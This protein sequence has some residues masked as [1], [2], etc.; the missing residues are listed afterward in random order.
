[1]SI[2]KKL[3]AV[4]SAAAVVAS[5]FAAAPANAETT[6]SF[7]NRTV[8]NNVQRD[9]DPTNHTVKFYSGEYFSLYYGA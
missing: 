1:M 2:S 6:Q 4:V 7:V 3:A 8:Q 9:L 5:M